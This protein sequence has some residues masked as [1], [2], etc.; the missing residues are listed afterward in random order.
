MVSVAA[1]GDEV[2]GGLLRLPLLRAI[3]CELIGIKI[4]MLREVK[5]IVSA[6]AVVGHGRAT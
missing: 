5:R 2:G 4:G 3:F 6:G 1:L